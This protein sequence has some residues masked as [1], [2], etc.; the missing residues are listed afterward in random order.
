V[1]ESLDLSFVGHVDHGK[2]TL[3]ARLLLDLGVIPDSKVVEMREASE[4]RSGTVELAFL[5]DAFQIERDQ[6]VTVDTTRVW[7]RTGV[8]LY[9]VADAPGHFEFLRHVV[10]GAVDAQLAVLV[11]D[12]R[13]GVSEQ[14][15]RHAALLGFLGVRD[16]IVAVNKMDLVVFDE[17]RFHKIARSAEDMLRTKNVRMRCALPIVA[18][19]GDNVVNVSRRIPWHDG[20]TLRK[21]LDRFEPRA[22]APSPLRLGVQDV[23]RRNGER[24]IAGRLQG[25]RLSVGDWLLFSPSGQSARIAKIHR[26][27]EDESPARDGEAV[28]VSLDRPLFVEAGHVASRPEEA[29][30]VTRRF[31]AEVFWMARRDL[32]NG[33]HVRLRIGS[34]DIA[35]RL[36]AAEPLRYGEIATVEFVTSA[37]VAVDVDRASFLSRFAVFSDGAIAGAGVVR[38]ISSAHE[39]RPRSPNVERESQIVSL[40]NRE[41]RFG[42]RSGIVWLTGLP[43]SGKSTLA[44]GLEERLF[45]KGWNAY[46]LDG[47]NLRTGLT[48]DLGFT[49][50]DRRENVRRI[51][52]AA[53]LFADA[54]FVAIVSLV[55]PSAA[56]REMA[57]S[58]FPQSFHEIHVTAPVDVCEQRDAKGLYLR[59]RAGE[60][61]NFTGVSGAYEPPSSPALTIDTAENSAPDCIDALVKYVTRSLRL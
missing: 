50:E 8:R 27:P 32:T 21:V 56:D 47:D 42:H 46:V 45:V 57:R 49:A 31:T 28:A 3:L 29:P 15:E 39:I 44:K 6:A 1:S 23:Y 58:L 22:K 61:P 7:F 26:F 5:L 35:A 2:S 20:Q 60:I 54:G 13:E 4:R 19:D 37:H 30:R 18:T 59:A 16:A 34:A 55:S 52:E 38:S 48:G 40:A 24:L 10:T 14:T 12:A 41:Q 33:A 25:D 51:G 9:S 53:A 11:I 17:R 43:C 36:E